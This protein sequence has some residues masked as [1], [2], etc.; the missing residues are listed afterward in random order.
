LTIAVTDIDLIILQHS[1]DCWV[2]ET[3]F[4]CGSPSISICSAGPEHSSPVMT[5]LFTVSRTISEDSRLPIISVLTTSVW[6][7]ISEA[8]AIFSAD[9]SPFSTFSLFSSFFP[10]TG[11]ALFLV[12]P[13]FWAFA[14]ALA[15]A[16]LAAAAVGLTADVDV[17][18]R[19]GVPD[20]GLVVAELLDLL[21][22]APLL[23]VATLFVV[24]LATLV[25]GALVTATV[26]LLAATLLVVELLVVALGAGLGRALEVELALDGCRE[27]D[28]LLVE[29]GLVGC[30]R[31]T[32]EEVGRFGGSVLVVAVLASIGLGLD[33]MVLDVVGFV[34]GLDGPF[35]DGLLESGFLSVVR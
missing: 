12:T 17:A 11:A 16:T 13:G 3:P 26:G 14:A 22:P 31:D 6:D 32:L 9:T 15:A 33:G 23:V 35:S 27:T 8:A 2:L 28:L 5:F 7:M 24:V 19:L 18:A 25:A 10:A 34:V 20:M 4:N 1:E 21:R 29:L 30:G